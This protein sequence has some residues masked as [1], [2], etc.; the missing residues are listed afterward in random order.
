[1]DSGDTVGLVFDTVKE[2]RGPRLFVEYQPA[3][4][5][6]P[7]ASLFLVYAEHDEGLEV[8]ADRIREEA[9]QWFRR[10]PIPLVASAVDS[11][12]DPIDV[13]GGD[14]R[15][16]LLVYARAGKI[17]TEWGRLGEF[18]MPSFDASPDNLLKIYSSIDHSTKEQRRQK[19]DKKLL[20][21][22]S[23]VRIII[24]FLFF[25]RAVVP[26]GVALAFYL[27]PVLGFLGL[28][29]TLADAA[30]GGLRVLGYLPK[31]KKEKQ[32]EEKRRKMEHH[33]YHC[34][35]N[36]RG[37]AALKAE[38]LGESLREKARQEARDLHDEN[39]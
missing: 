4:E 2:S 33:D 8:I 12:D 28:L 23:G 37:F 19:A 38:N 16:D 11:V 14:D 18:S 1:M 3:N 9:L 29:G 7:F 13:S 6:M 39:R 20:E 15:R 30:I 36:P 32:A 26:A 34:Q 5:T 31:S 21:Q 10:F 27:H 17:V 22:R 25:R 24:A 35:L